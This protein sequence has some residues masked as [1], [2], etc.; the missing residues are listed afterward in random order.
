MFTKQKISMN[1]KSVYAGRIREVVWKTSNGTIDVTNF[2][3]TRNK[4][5]VSQLKV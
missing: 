2:S 3:L 4:I 1:I 5:L